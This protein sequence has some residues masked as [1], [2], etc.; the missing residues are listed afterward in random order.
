MYLEVVICWRLPQ[1]SQHH[2]SSYNEEGFSIKAPG[3]CDLSNIF[4][5]RVLLLF[6]RSESQNAAMRSALLSHRRHARIVYT[7]RGFSYATALY[8][9]TFAVALLAADRWTARPHWRAAH[10]RPSR[11]RPLI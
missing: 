4:D 11:R 6:P 2:P 7:F 1:G 5:T 8:V 9:L 10:V 3:T